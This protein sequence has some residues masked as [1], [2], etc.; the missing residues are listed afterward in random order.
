MNTMKKITLISL[1]AIAATFSFSS[2]QKN[3]VP[4]PEQEVKGDF[5]IF[6]EI[7]K[8]TIDGYST[9]WADADA[10]NVFHAENGGTNYGS[11]N[12][13][14]IAEAD[15]S[16][17][18]FTGTLSGALSASNDWY[19][20]Y[21]YNYNIITPSNPSKGYLNIGCNNS[22]KTAQVQN[23]NNSNA[24]LAGQ[25][26]PLYAQ[27]K[28]VASDA[29]VTLN[30]KPVASI[31]K[32][33]VK[34]DTD[35]E[36]T[37]TDVTFS[38]KNEDVIGSYFI[39]FAGNE[40]VFTPS[41]DTY[42][43]KSTTLKVS[44]GTAIASG[45]TGEFYLAIKPFSTSANDALTFSVNG[46]EKSTDEAFTFKAG[47]IKTVN[48]S[49][50]KKISS[51]VLSFPDDNKAN[52]MVNNYTS[53]WIAKIGE[54][55]WTVSQFNNANWTGWTYI[56]AG[57]KTAGA[58]TTPYIKTNAAF[59]EAINCVAISYGACSSLDKISNAK[60]IV[61]SD[62]D[63]SQ[64]VKEYALT[65]TSATEVKCDITPTANRYYKISYNCG[66]GGANGYLIINKVTYFY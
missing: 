65:I 13:F 33:V 45:K 22:A 34:N 9:K 48:F 17:G 59:K 62:A 54:K 16:T 39:D 58:T 56:K 53:D 46:L 3:E 2:C 15:L 11:N 47:Q 44:N 5:S 25:Y 63:F 31:L 38:A 30:F 8:T 41:G 27:A 37:I 36:L 10:I 28:N 64:N 24:H 26:F 51:Y 50:D 7:T 29:A 6:A 4:A 43:S 52:N 12:N 40:P 49:Y 35:E 55:E 21:P 32:V 66:V 20:L 57:R 18:R 14:S 61:A 1:A 60:L 42:V 23:G 19:A